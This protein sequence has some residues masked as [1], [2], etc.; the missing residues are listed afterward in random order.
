MGDCI[1]R[2]LF[3]HAAKREVEIVLHNLTSNKKKSFSFDNIG[4]AVFTDPVVAGVGGRSIAD[5][6]SAGQI[7][8]FQVSGDT[9]RQA[10]A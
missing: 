2:A 9:S 3:A 4:W 5:Q 6:T 7:F 10:P 8:F 1:G